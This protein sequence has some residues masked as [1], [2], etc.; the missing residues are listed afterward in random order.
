MNANWRV[1]AMTFGWVEGR[2]PTQA[3]CSLMGRCVMSG[4][5]RQP[6][7]AYAAWCLSQAQVVT[8]VASDGRRRKAC[9][10]TDAG[11]A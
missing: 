6:P 3:V 11:R 2:K 10:V 7:I 1:N 8:L 5:E 9:G 4:S